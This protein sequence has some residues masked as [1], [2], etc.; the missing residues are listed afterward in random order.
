MACGSIPGRR[1][2]DSDGSALITKPCDLGAEHVAN[3]PHRANQR[4]AIGPIV[5]LLAQ[6]RDQ[7]IDRAIE[8]RPLASAQH[9]EEGGP[10]QGKARLA[11]KRDQQIE[12]RRRQVDPLTSGTNE[13]PHC[14]IESPTRENVK[15]LDRLQG[16]R[17]SDFEVAAPDSALNCGQLLANLFENMDLHH[18]PAFDDHCPA[19]RH[20]AVIRSVTYAVVN[21]LRYVTQNIYLISSWTQCSPTS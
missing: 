9:A 11:Q 16:L 4:R 5:K 14:F 17:A 19:N 6:S 15:S 8:I 12:L 7:R 21:K 20:S 1:A 18:S 3:A 10:R 13:V 2:R